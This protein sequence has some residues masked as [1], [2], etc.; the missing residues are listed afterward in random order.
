MKLLLIMPDAHMH[1]LRVG[2]HLRSMREAPLT[3]A[4][5][6]GLVPQGRGWE[7][8]L[9]D[10]SVDPVP[11]DAAVDLV[12]I[13]VITGTARR[14]YE[15]AAHFRA[16]GIP[17]VLGGVHVTIMPKEARRHADAIVVG[18]AERSWPR[19]LED[20]AAGRMAAEYCDEPP[21]GDALVGVPAPR[22]DLM[23]RSGYM[24]PDTVQATRG[25]KHVCDF[26]SVPAV[27][28]RYYKRPV[29]DVVR[30]VRSLRG[31]Y[32][33]FNDVSL[34]EDREYALELFAALAPLGRKWG[35]L[36]TVA[37]TQDP[38]LLD[39]MAKSGC[40]YLLFGFESVSQAALTAIYKGFNR[41]VDYGDAMRA[42]HERGISVQGC[43]VFG[44]DHDD[45]SVFEATLARVQELKVDIPRYSLYTPYPGTRLFQ[46]LLAEER[47]ISFNW[48]D[49]DTMHVVIRPR[50]MTPEE[51]YA[52]FKWAYRETFR[53]RRIVGRVR[54]PSVNSVVNFVGNLA[55]VMFVR[56]LYREARYALPCSADQPAVDPAQFQEVQ[57]AWEAHS[58][59]G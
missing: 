42:L 10:E 21:A 12:G 37:V 22:L 17:V 41:P 40:I 14:A 2:P 39:L 29:A 7:C 26:C 46:R 36:A 47:I 28:P 55:Y 1:K 56:R 31:R 33:A 58:C 49:Y 27:W 5:L 54:S 16:R 9:V 3:I 45:R 59:R 19:L 6:A 24:V 51:L 8:R 34:C 38:E 50:N 44:L 23:R 13:S 25:C 30:D 57:R 15:L 20:F 4:V 52:G 43:F 32:F 18:M 53:L 35:G 48:D 11:L